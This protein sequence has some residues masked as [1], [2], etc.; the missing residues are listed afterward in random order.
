M[1]WRP[2]LIVSPIPVIEIAGPA[3]LVGLV[4]DLLDVRVPVGDVVFEQFR[5]GGCRLH[6]PV[7]ERS[8]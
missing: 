2:S 3:K 7:F 6:M 5:P 4:Y 8:S 1:S